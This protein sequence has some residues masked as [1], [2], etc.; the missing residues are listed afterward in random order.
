[1]KKLIKYQL[2]YR[3]RPECESND[4][5]KYKIYKPVRDNSTGM[6]SLITAQRRCVFFAT[7]TAAWWR[8]GAGER[9]EKG[10]F[11]ILLYG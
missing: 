7:A 10:A 2:I 11:F 4:K 5:K 3:F 9:T 1:M 6:A 8:V